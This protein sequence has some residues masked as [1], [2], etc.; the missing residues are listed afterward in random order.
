MVVG[1][2]AGV[3]VVRERHYETFVF[4]AVPSR[5]CIALVA[6]P[7]SCTQ[8]ATDIPV[9]MVRLMNMV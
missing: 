8:V 7:G 1:A 4:A 6:A 3:D 2:G 5:K 9:V